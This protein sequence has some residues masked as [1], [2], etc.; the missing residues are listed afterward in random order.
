MRALAQQLTVRVRA[1]GMAARI[2][3]LV[4]DDELANVHEADIAHLLRIANEHGIPV[5]PPVVR[6]EPASTNGDAGPT[7]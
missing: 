4:G 6:T 7:A 5:P 1:A 3:A 2:A